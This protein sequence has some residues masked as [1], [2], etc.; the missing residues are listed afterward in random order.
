[1]FPSLFPICCLPLRWQGG[2]HCPPTWG[3]EFST[4]SQI[5]AFLEAHPS[6][7]PLWN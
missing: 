6:S 1:L 4:L 3:L 2:F 7:R 5:R